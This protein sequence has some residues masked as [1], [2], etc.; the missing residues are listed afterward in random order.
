MPQL[1]FVT[2]GARSGKSQFAQDCAHS[3]PGR[4]V[5]IATAEPLDEEMAVKITAHRKGRPSEWDTVE[6]PRHLGKAVMDCAATYDVLLV[7]C[8][9]LWISNLLTNNSLGERE[10]KSEVH[11]LVENC[12]T[13]SSTVIIVSNEL[14]MGIVPLDSLT[15]L[16]R[17]IVGKANQQIAAAA[18]EVFL[19]V[20]GISLKIKE[21]K[22]AAAGSQKSEL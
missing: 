21:K 12:K 14:G 9:T 8:L 5:Y 20:S 11:N 7:D 3:L 2:G 22:N 18:D 6:E 17:D 15:R 4:K 19:L 10:I 13:V 1:I 16:Y